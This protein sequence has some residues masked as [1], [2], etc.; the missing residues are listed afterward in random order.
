MTDK[1]PV[2]LCQGIIRQ[3]EH[4]VH[5][6]ILLLGEVFLAADAPALGTGNVVA[7]VTDALQFGNLAEHGAYLVLRLIAQMGI[8]DLVEVLRNLNLHVV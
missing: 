5:V 7:G 4:L 3:F 1:N 8:G 2:H 6:V